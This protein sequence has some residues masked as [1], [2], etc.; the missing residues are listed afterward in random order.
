VV[1]RLQVNFLSHW[2]LAEQL[3]GHQRQQRKKHKTQGQ[4]HPGTRLVMLSSLTHHAG[5]VQWEDMQVGAGSV[6]Y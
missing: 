4:E 2:L 6:G 1:P 3:I 5:S